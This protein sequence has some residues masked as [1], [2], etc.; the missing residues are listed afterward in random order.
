MSYTCLHY[1]IIFSVK[2]RRA[3]LNSSEMDRLCDYCGGILRNHGGTLHQGGGPADHIHLAISLD[4]KTSI[5][6]TV[7]TLKANT[8]RW[9]H[10]NYADLG[11]F[12]W[13]DGYAAFSVSHSGLPSVIDYIRSQ[14]EHHQKLSYRQELE[15]FF[16]KHGI[17][18]DIRFFDSE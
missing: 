6:E 8:S 1:H 9:I 7:R 16:A 14:P 15:Q 5:V 4:P 2:G 17:E 18:Y 10:E 11:T 12:A 3:S 13:Q